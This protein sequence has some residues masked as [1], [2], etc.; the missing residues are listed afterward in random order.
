[1]Q[2]QELFTVADAARKLKLK[3]N[4]V[5]CLI[6]RKQL[7]AETMFGRKMIR[8]AEVNRYNAERK[9]VGRPAAKRSRRV[10]K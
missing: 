7:R 10:P 3:P 1:M 4:T 9:G 2:L 6:E 8:I 5:Y